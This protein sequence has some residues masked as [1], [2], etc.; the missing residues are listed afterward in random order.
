MKWLQ[1]LKRQVSDDFRSNISQGVE[2][3]KLELTDLE[4]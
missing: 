4:T 3:T 2:P 1:H